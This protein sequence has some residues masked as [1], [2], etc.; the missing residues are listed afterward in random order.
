MI[1]L[2]LTHYHAGTQATLGFTNHPDGND[3]R[4]EAA[5]GISRKP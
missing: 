3:W 5:F 1:V 4:R 2:M